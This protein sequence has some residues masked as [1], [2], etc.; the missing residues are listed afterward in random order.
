MEIKNKELSFQTLKGDSENEVTLS[1]ST[2]GD[3]NEKNRLVQ[4]DS[5][6]GETTVG[7]DMARDAYHQVVRDCTTSFRVNLETHEETIELTRR[8]KNSAKLEMEIEE[9]KLLKRFREKFERQ[10]RNEERR[11][12]RIEYL[13]QMI[14]EISS[15]PEDIPDE[16]QIEEVIREAEMQY[17]MREKARKIF[18]VREKVY[19]ID[20]NKVAF[21]NA[22]ISVKVNPTRI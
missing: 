18:R 15:D 14:A 12:A 3:R 22:T 21:I 16:R 20:G 19:D 13:K 1:R 11:R 4:R 8:R 17:N 2:S 9:A 7:G 6:L 10:D 5:Q